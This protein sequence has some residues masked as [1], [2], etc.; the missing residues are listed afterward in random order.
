[1]LSIYNENLNHLAYKHYLA[2]EEMVLRSS[3]GKAKLHFINVWLTIVLEEQFS[4]RKLITAN[5]TELEA[6]AKKLEGKSPSKSVKYLGDIYENY[7]AGSSKTTLKID[8]KPYKASHFV[9]NLELTVCPYC[10][11]NYIFNVSDNKKVRRLSEL[12]HFYP[13]EKYP[14]LYMSFYNLVPVCHN[15]NHIKSNSK[16]KYINPYK[17]FISDSNILFNIKIKGANFI[18][19]PRQFKLGWLLSNEYQEM[20]YDLKLHRIYPVHK[21]IISD[22]IKKKFIYTD[23][24]VE[25]VYQL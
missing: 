25:D 7:F 17:E 16:A 22:I 12:D 8:K 20:F 24:Y 18:T 14:A 23:N 13:K 1:M 11:R 3:N 10:N 4:L 6:L 19:N 21:D 15:C 2:V 5:S 9:R